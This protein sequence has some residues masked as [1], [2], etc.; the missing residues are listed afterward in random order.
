MRC[1]TCGEHAAGAFCDAHRIPTAAERPVDPYSETEDL[2]ELEPEDL[3]WQ[4]PIDAGR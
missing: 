1:V 4:E 2:A 3:M